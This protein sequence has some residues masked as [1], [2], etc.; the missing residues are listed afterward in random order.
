MHYL[1]GANA[2]SVRLGFFADDAARD[3]SSKVLDCNGG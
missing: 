3:A 1:Q 2:T